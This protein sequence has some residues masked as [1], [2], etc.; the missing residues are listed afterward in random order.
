MTQEYM[1]HNFS[2]VIVEIQE[3][4]VLNCVTSSGITSFSFG[5]LYRIIGS[6]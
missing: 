3:V 4:V 6:V 5:V 1:N 2:N